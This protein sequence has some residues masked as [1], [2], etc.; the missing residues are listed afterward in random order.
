MAAVTICSDF[1]APK[2]K[3]AS[4][5]GET[6]STV[7]LSICQE[8]M[9]LDAMILFLEC[10]ILSQLFHSPFSLSSRASYNLD[11]CNSCLP[12]LLFILGEILSIA[13][14]FSSFCF[15]QFSVLS[16][17]IKFHWF[18]FS[19]ISFFLTLGLICSFVCYLKLGLLI[20]DFFV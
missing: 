16:S 17:Y 1:G 2:I 20:W 7:S 5:V 4:T 3:S 6:V 13:L 14:I 12:F 19:V 11:F 10:W 9:G 8:V 18:V 15:H